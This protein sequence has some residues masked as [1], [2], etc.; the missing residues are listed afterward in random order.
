[1]CAWAP[2]ALLHTNIEISL[3]R[4]PLLCTIKLI[5]YRGTIWQLHSKM[6]VLSSETHAKEHQ[7]LRTS[8]TNRQNMRSCNLL[9]QWIVCMH[10]CKKNYYQLKN[11]KYL[12]FVDSTLCAWDIHSCRKY[13]V[14]YFSWINFQRTHNF[15][16]RTLSRRNVLCFLSVFFCL[17]IIRLSK[18]HLK[19]T[20]KTSRK[21]PTVNMDIIVFII[22]FKITC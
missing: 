18:R 15:F 9:M 13:Y 17:F 14:S 1:M 20:D 5:W 11:S 21:I 22:S 10:F 6:C 2:F 4:V 8:K 19:K 16:Y 3:G 7:E 12:P